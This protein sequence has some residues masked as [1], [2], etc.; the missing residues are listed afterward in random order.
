MKIPRLF[1]IRFL[2]VSVVSIFVGLVSVAAQTTA[3]TYQ[4]QLNDGVSAAS[5]TYQME[6]R[7]F[8]ALSAGTQIGST[9]TNNTVAVANGI[10][11]VSLDFS[12]TPFTTGANRWLQVSVRKAA[13]PPG[14]TTLTPRQQITSSPYSL[15]TLSATSADSLSAVCVTCVTDSQ[16][17]TV[18][19]SKVTGAVS[20]AT[21]AGNVTGT[22]ALTN[23]GTGATNATN[24][25]TNL[26][27]GSLATITPTGTAN[28][29]TFLRGD[30][31]WQIVSSGG[32]LVGMIF[33]GRHASN[34]NAT[35]PYY[36]SIGDGAILNTAT[37]ATPQQQAEYVMPIAGTI[38]T[39]RVDT[40]GAFAN[41]V[42]YTLYKN[43]VATTFQCT[44]A[45]GGNPGTCSG[46]G[47]LSIAAGDK[48]HIRMENFA[49]MLPS[50][51]SGFL[52]YTGIHFK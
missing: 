32:S 7:L 29:T 36:L 14:F 43:G 38:D 34:S 15:R 19:G 18:S 9:I 48:L 45:G 49:G 5:G 3:F 44:I 4:G 12:S 42:D 20:S 10:F 2:A 35:S 47:T 28:S 22:V 27:L 46:T 8:D 26:G 25:R 33:A 31:S 6:F 11:T 52:V 51:L 50:S 30:N 1:F 16:I 41:S 21:T 17:N 40:V 39:F 23:G 13:D 37:G 24:A